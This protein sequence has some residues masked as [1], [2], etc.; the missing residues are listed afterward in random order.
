MSGSA[1]LVYKA[2]P[3][4]LPFSGG[5]KVRLIYEI[6]RYLMDNV[7]HRTEI[8]YDHFKL[9]LIYTMYIYNQLAML[10]ILLLEV[11]RKKKSI[12]S[13]KFEMKVIRTV[14]YM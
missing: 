1:V 12:T 3:R 13:Y 10:K 2:H 4:L 6:I 8:N 14:K 5:K 11:N 9:L 7:Y